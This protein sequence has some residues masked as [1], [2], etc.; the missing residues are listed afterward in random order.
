LI[1]RRNW[2]SVEEERDNERHD[3]IENIE[4]EKER[5]RKER[6]GNSDD[7]P[8][9][10]I[11][12]SQMQQKLTKRYLSRSTWPTTNP[13]GGGL[14]VIP[15]EK[16]RDHVSCRSMSDRHPWNALFHFSFLILRQ[17][18]GLVGRGISPSQGRYLHKHRIDTDKHPCLEWDP[19]PRS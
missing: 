4:W 1:I 18:V 12:W 6:K 10:E 13:T 3:E 8:W 9:R 11:S 19:N 14:A 5:E 7:N 16:S 15:T 17:L 2:L